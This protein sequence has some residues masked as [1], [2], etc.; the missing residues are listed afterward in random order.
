MKKWNKKGVV[1][2]EAIISVG[3]LIWV[4]L[5]MGL[6]VKT[7]SNIQNDSIKIVNKLNIKKITNHLEYMK[8]RLMAIGRNTEY[9]KNNDKYAGWNILSVTPNWK[10]LNDLNGTF[11]L[12][13]NF[14]ICNSS[15][16]GYDKCLVDIPADGWGYLVTAWESDQ[17]DVKNDG[18]IEKKANKHFL[19]NNEDYC[20][21]L[22]SSC[23]GYRIIIKNSPSTSYEEKIYINKAWDTVILQ[24][25]KIVTIEIQDGSTNGT[26]KYNY[27][28][29]LY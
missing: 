17:F 5:L 16:T 13:E 1:L 23:I 27:L 26:Q 25:K 4:L 3:I 10:S 8:R 19:L 6:I 18:T 9:R 22:G 12:E 21:E 29:S 2:F 28:L 15:S 11:I 24:D 7:T 14:G 20:N